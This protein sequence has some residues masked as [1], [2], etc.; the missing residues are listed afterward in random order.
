MVVEALPEHTCLFWVYLPPV[1]LTPPI[2]TIQLLLYQSG[3]LLLIPHMSLNQYIVCKAKCMAR[4]LQ[5]I[6]CHTNHVNI[7][8]HR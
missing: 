6:L 4:G 2:K 7:E 3:C 8:Q 1:L 5:L